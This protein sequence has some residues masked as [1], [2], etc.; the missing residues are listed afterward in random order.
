MDEF[1]KDLVKVFGRILKRKPKKEKEEH[2]LNF[3]ICSKCKRKIKK[4]DAVLSL[5]E[6]IWYCE[7][8][9]F[10]RAE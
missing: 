3:I 5:P 4:E 7:K 6:E 1:L 9:F 10:G 2:P 8:C